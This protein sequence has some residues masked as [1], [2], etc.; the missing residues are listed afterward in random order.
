LAGK[1][2]LNYRKSTGGKT[3]PLPDFYIGALAAI[4]NMTLIT[5]DQGLFKTYFPKLN[6]IAP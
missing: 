1:C 3:A 6:I 2:F 5:R 4:S